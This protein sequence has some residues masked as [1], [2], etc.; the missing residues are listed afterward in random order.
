MLKLT[1]IMT[2][3]NASFKVIKQ[4]GAANGDARISIVT[5]A[6]SEA[7]LNEITEKINNLAEMQLLAAYKVLEE[8]K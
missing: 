3:A 2:Q 7:Q 8:E 6:M 5:H 1:E 4:T